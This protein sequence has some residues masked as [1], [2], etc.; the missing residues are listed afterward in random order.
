MEQITRTGHIME[1]RDGVASIR[2]DLP[3]SC[4][5]CGSRGTCGSGK[6]A[7]TTV[8]LPVS[9]AARPGETVT[10]SIA[11]G[12]LVRRAILVYFL[13]AVTTLLGTVSLADGGDAAAVAGAAVGLLLGLAILRMFGRGMSRHGEPTTMLTSSS[14]IHPHP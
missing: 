2:I 12:S 5:S 4:G 1:I 14:C 10:L 9:S 8:R 7:G 11:E 6:S 3:A 13:P